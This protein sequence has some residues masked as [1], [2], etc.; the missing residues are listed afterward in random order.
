M[1]WLQSQSARVNTA[2]LFIA[3]LF[4]GCPCAV[5]GNL[6][7]VPP[8]ALVKATCDRV[9]ALKP[10]GKQPPCVRWQT[11]GAMQAP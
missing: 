6:P 4:L 9:E 5:R 1:S 3:L 10:I 2:G 7:G 8:V 11:D